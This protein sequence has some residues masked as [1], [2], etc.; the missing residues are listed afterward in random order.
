MRKGNL[1]RSNRPSVITPR[2]GP[3]RCRLI[4]ERLEPRSLLAVLFELGAEHPIRA[5]VPSETEYNDFGLDW[6]GGAEPFDDLAWAQSTGSP[7]GVG[8]DKMPSA[9]DPMIGIDLETSMYGVSP[10]FFLRAVFDV[11]DPATVD[12]L[13]LNLRYDDGFVAWLNGVEIARSNAETVYPPWSTTATA[14]QEASSFDALNLSSDIEHLRAGRNVLAIRGLNVNVADDDALVQFTLIGERRTGPPVAVDD[15]TTTTQDAPITIDVLANDQEASH[16]IDPSSVRITSPPIYGTAIVHANGTITYTPLPGYRGE[17]VLAYAVRDSSGGV[18]ARQTL[19][20]ANAPA[21]VIVPPS[22]FSTNW[23]GGAAGFDDSNWTSGTLGVGYDASP[24]PVDYNSYIGT[25]VSYMANINQSVHIRSSFNVDNPSD[26]RSLQ[27]RMRY[28]DG[29]VAFLNGTVIASRNAP[30]LGFLQHNSGATGQAADANAINFELFDVSAFRSALIAGPNVL[31]IHGL[32]FGLG[33]SD[34]LIQP[35]LVADVASSGATSNEATVDITVHS[36]TPVLAVDDAYRTIVNSA[37]AVDASA[38]ILGNDRNL[39]DSEPT[40]LQTV[41][42][43]TLSLASDGSFQYQPQPGFVGADRFVYGVHAE[44]FGTFEIDALPSRTS[45]A[46]TARTSFGSAISADGDRMA[47]G[48]RAENA[49]YVYRRTAEGWTL[50]QRI[51]S[52]VSGEQFGTA[53][54]L[55]GNSLVVGAPYSFSLRGAAITFEWNGAAWVQTSRT[56]GESGLRYFGLKVAIDGDVFAASTGSNGGAVS[57]YRRDGANWRL[58]SRL[59]PDGSSDFGSEMVLREDWLAVT[60]APGNG[61]GTA[62]LFHWNGSFW[63]RITDLRPQE[64]ESGELFGGGL[65]FDG[66]LLAI[67][68]PDFDGAGQNSGAVFIFERQTTGWREIAKLTASDDRADLRLGDSLALRENTLVV[69]AIGQSASAYVFRK[70]NGVWQEFAKIGD[71]NAPANAITGTSLSMTTN[72]VHVSVL[73]DFSGNESKGYVATFGTSSLHRAEVRIEVSTSPNQ[74]PVGMGDSYAT[75]ED[76]TLMASDVL[77]NDIDADGNNLAAVL[78]HAPARG[79]LKWNT[80]GQFEYTGDENAH[81]EDSFW[82]RVFDGQDYSEPIH[83]SIEVIP[84]NDAPLASPDA[85][86]VAEDRELA[87]DAIAG[88][89]GNDTDVDTPSLTAALVTQPRYGSIVLGSD[90]GFTYQPREN[91]VGDDVFTYNV[92]DGALNSLPVEVRLTITAVD[93]A[94]GGVADTYEVRTNSI[95]NV[96]GVPNASTTAAEFPGLTLVATL[97]NA[98]R[99]ERLEYSPQFRLLFAQTGAGK[100]S[101]VDTVSGQEISARFPNTLFTD[102]DLTADGRYFFAADFGGEPVAARPDRPS[103]IHRFD[104]LSRT[105]TLQPAPFV[106]YRIEAMSATMAIVVWE[107]QHTPVTIVEYDGSPTFPAAELANE[108]ATS[109]AD[110]EYDAASGMLYFRNGESTSSCVGKTETGPGWI[111]RP[112]AETCRIQSASNTP[113][114]LSIDGAFFYAHGRRYDVSDFSTSV[115]RSGICAST[116]TIEF[117][118]GRAANAVTGE[119]LQDVPCSGSEATLADNGMDYWAYINSTYRHYRIPVYGRGVLANDNDVESAPLTAEVV[120]QPSHGTLEF[121]ANGAFTYVPEP[122]YIG[123]DGFQ[124]R[125]IANGLASAATTVNISVTAPPPEALPDSY[126]VLAGETLTVS[127]ASGVTSNDVSPLGLPL[128]AIVTQPPAHGTLTLSTDGAFEY[129]PAAGFFG[130]DSF[131]YRVSAGGSQSPPATVSISVRE[132]NVPPVAVADFYRVAVDGAIDTTAGPPAAIS[133]IGQGS[134]WR[135]FD[136]GTNVDATWQSPSYDDSTW[137][138]GNAPLGY[139]DPVT[140]IVRCGPSPTCMTNNHMTTYFRRE[141]A[142]SNAASTASLTVNLRRDDGAVIYINGV[143]LLRDNMPA[144]P[145]LISP[146]TPAINALSG[147]QET[148]FVASTITAAQLAARGITLREGVNAI[149]VEVHQ[150]NANSSDTLFDLS[151]TALAA[152]NVGLLANDNDPNNDVLSAVVIDQ[153]QSGTLA[154][155]P[156]GQFQYTPDT[157][158]RGVDRFSYRV[159]DGEFLSE[160]TT[161]TIV[162]APSGIAAQDLNADGAINAGDVAFLM[163]SYGKASAAKPIEGDLDGD[164]RIGVR[165]VIALRNAITPAPAPAAAAVAVA[166]DRAIISSPGDSEGMRVDRRLRRPSNEVL[167]I[168]TIVTDRALAASVDEPN[169][170]IGRR[171]RLSVRARG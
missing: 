73:S 163:A 158:Y 14:E 143:E 108:R 140:T 52:N 31:A 88:V 115:G 111:M 97:N 40:L 28:D 166:K 36:A 90:G 6:T 130:N 103:W 27:L 22:G 126:S 104:A 98:S 48:A 102:F 77:A 4:M 50:E 162:V 129:R 123:Q 46:S 67:G 38:G 13:T 11:E 23:R 121:H 66:S 10:T 32:N 63:E 79:S 61:Y 78:W 24:S 72:A 35:E 68:A 167:R 133:L 150:Q 147:S 51:A 59:D 45:T 91:F 127:A 105:W 155:Q 118:S 54:A 151:L 56:F 160:L 165:D 74:L 49:V 135:Y 33:S 3:N 42:N 139:G 116:G 84:E 106:A 114:V 57:I 170:L 112:G 137:L 146:T 120:Q 161:V 101:V 43:G 2:G 47:I 122:G 117:L 95:L 149:A 148:T 94:P 144:A 7:N 65:A 53:V 70:E 60:G 157:G 141:F 1:R 44:E 75:T 100:I 80:D 20:T 64:A 69:S 99:P 21:K 62:Y 82:Y 110:V 17:D 159:S 124:Y 142:L 168:S 18:V 87:I 83:V 131:T 113:S 93:D 41:E 156:D 85:Y 15:I 86:S 76:L 9:Y 154:L 92:S 12:V 89:L 8:Y 125:A 30:D 25:N 34:L 71:A 152:S 55:S 19:L 171:S 5:I 39:A 134:T 145:A 29:F 119:N 96:D 128:I 109:S 136:T 81:G 138:A 58:Q 153:P 107:D 169:S 37:L 164:G 26:V 132:V 16:P